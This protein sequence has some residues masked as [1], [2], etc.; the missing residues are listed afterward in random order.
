MGYDLQESLNLYAEMGAKVKKKA[1]V[2][3]NLSDF[4]MNSKEDIATL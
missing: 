3:I 4:A 1:N 2:P